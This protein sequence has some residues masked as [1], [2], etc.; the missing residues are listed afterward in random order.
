M[1]PAG[2]AYMNS[3]EREPQEFRPRPRFLSL[4]FFGLAAFLLAD[5]VQ[6]FL[7]W[8]IETALAWNSGWEQVWILD[9]AVLTDPGSPFYVSPP[10]ESPW[11]Y[12]TLVVAVSFLILGAALVY[13]WPTD[14]TLA[15]RLYIHLSAV[16]FIL[17]GT[18]GIPLART[19]IL[20]NG[21]YISIPVAVGIIALGAITLL[22]VQ[23]SLMVLLQQFW[24]LFSWKERSSLFTIIELPGLLVLGVLF[25]FNEFRGGA[26]AVMLAAIV[27]FLGTIRYSRRTIYERVSTHTA[28]RAAVV[29]WLLVTVSIGATVWFFGSPIIERPRHAL[30]WSSQR[31]AALQS[32]GEI[33]QQQL[34]DPAQ[35]E[36]EPVIRWSKER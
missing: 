33:L 8:G 18:I 23:R 32:H 13:L 27:L 31:G 19:E 5:L 6:A 34:R 21:E 26:A 22:A 24:D 36:E 11:V 10:L 14:S 25:W 3:Y 16:V 17:K 15:S 12:A 35:L 9:I 7:T 29:L 20:S 4:F 30:T 28:G 2:E 1:A